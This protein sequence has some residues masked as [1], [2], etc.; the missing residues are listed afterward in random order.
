MVNKEEI[1]KEAATRSFWA[2]CDA[3]QYEVDDFADNPEAEQAFETAKKN[4][5]DI[6]NEALSQINAKQGEH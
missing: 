1:V 2:V 5:V 6:I 3:I 4:I